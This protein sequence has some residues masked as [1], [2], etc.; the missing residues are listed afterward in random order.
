MNDLQ[1]KKIRKALLIT[2]L[3]VFLFIV[4]LFGFIGYIFLFSAKNT[5]IYAC[6]LKEAK[7]NQTIIKKIGEPIEPGMLVWTENWSSGR[8]SE[9]AFF[10][11]S[12]SGPKGQGTLYVEAF[13]TLNYS[14]LKLIFQGDGK[15]EVVFEGRS[16]CDVERAEI[17]SPGAQAASR[18]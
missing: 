5:K 12:L 18:Q 3:V 11:T 14:S 17:K 4:P 10:N 2:S 6:A 1:A 13:Q 7:K 8:F 16:L 9:R 15:P